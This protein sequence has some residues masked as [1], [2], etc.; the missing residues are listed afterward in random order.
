MTFLDKFQKETALIARYGEEK[1][2]LLWV[3]GKYLGRSDLDQLATEGLTDAEDDHKIDFLLIDPDNTR[4]IIVQSAYKNKG[5]Y[6]ASSNKAADL[7]T[8]IA[9]LLNGDLSHIRNNDE[10]KFLNDMREIVEDVR[11]ALE[12]GEIDNI[13][14]LYVHNVAESQNVRNELETVKANLIALLKGQPT[15]IDVDA[16]ELDAEAIARIINYED[17]AIIIDEHIEIPSKPKFTEQ[18]AAWNAGIFTIDGKWLQE[19]FINYGNDLF[20][21]NYRGFLG[22]GKRGKKKINAGIIKTTETEPTNFWAYNNGITI[23]TTKIMHDEKKPNHTIL[24]G[25]SIING[26]QTTGSI[27]HST[28]ENLDQIKILCR[29]IEVKD[30]TTIGSI[31]E[32]NNTQNEIT[33]WD[34]FSKNPEQE[35]IASEFDILGYKYSFKRG[36]DSS[37]HESELGIYSVAQP[38]AAFHGYYLEASNGKNNTFEKRYGEVFNNSKAKHLLLAYC[39][40]SSID[41]NRSELNNKNKNQGLTSD[42][43]KQLS[44]LKHLKFKYFLLA[45]IGSCFESI[46]GTAI[47]IKQVAFENGVAGI[48]HNNIIQLIQKCAPV[49]QQVLRLTARAVKKDFTSIVYNKEEFDSISESV[50]DGLIS[51]KEMLDNPN[52]FTTFAELIAPNG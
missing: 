27:G 26:A 42:E 32:Y 2:F 4:L 28:Q 39:L 12:A 50:S 20:S 18:S 22:A 16:R 17:A 15:T 51:L 13:E 36:G 35:R 9:W 8:A 14:I 25:I 45:I 31:I 52:T 24:D 41:L 47:D 37:V 19:L 30:P 48:R 44:L 1:A 49:T 11:S 46:V 33:S 6:K 40:L 7:N 29:V 10:N 38:T 3:M 23:L 5:F 34:K 43:Q 21:A